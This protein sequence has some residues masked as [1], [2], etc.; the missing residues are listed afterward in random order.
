MPSGVTETIT[1]V[2]GYYFKV[3]ITIPENPN[4]S[5]R[6]L[7]IRANQPNGLSRELVQTAQQQAINLMMDSLGLN[8]PKENPD[9]K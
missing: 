9:G 3:T 4:T 5:G 7:T 1:N 6:T 2:S 8:K